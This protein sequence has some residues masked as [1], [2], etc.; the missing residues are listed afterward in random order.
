MGNP[1]GE[2]PW[3]SPW[4]IHMEHPHIDSQ[5]KIPMGSTDDCIELTRGTYSEKVVSPNVLLLFEKLPKRFK[6]LYKLAP[7]IIEN[8]QTMSARQHRDQTNERRT[9]YESQTNHRIF[10]Y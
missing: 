3:D 8:E 2:S 4:G 1:N 9:T 6:G 5:G 7:D 10:P